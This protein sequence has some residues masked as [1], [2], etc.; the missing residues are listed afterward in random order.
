M[1]VNRSSNEL[2]SMPYLIGAVD[3]SGRRVALLV[4]NTGD[5][6]PGVRRRQPTSPNPGTTVFWALPL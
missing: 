4:L 1:K 5:P 3:L 6:F 2:E